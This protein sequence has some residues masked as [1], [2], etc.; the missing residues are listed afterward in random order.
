MKNKEKLETL[1]NLFYVN[2]I[3]HTDQ[4]IHGHRIFTLSKV[5]CGHGRCFYF[6]SFL[7]CS[8]SSPVYW[9][10]TLKVSCCVMTAKWWFFLLN[11]YFLQQLSSLNWQLLNITGN[12]SPSSDK[13]DSNLCLSVDCITASSDMLTSMDTAVDPCNDFYQ[14]CEEE[15]LKE[16]FLKT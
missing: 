6:R 15:K 8:P 9:F 1:F 4:A 14:V 12:T 3:L 7:S 11:F 16:V 13:N 5:T 2:F 10:S